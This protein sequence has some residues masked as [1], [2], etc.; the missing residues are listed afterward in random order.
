MDK[1]KEL[2]IKHVVSGQLV[3]LS[4]VWEKQTVVIAF[5]R[6]WGWQLCRAWA[7][8]LDRELKPQLDA[9][10]VGLVVVGLE[11]LGVQTF[12]DGKYF[13]GG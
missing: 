11:E 5:L 8:E 10:G 12:L 6:R 4:S 2:M 9:H 7:T 3:P 1:V 13:S